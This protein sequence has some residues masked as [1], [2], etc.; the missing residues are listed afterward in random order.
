MHPNFMSLTSRIAGSLVRIVVL[1]A[2]WAG[3][4]LG[5]VDARPASVGYYTEAG[6]GATTFLG[7]AADYSR[8]GP[9][10]DIRTGYD[11]LSWLSLGILVGASTHEATVPPPPEDEYYQLYTLAAEVRFGFLLDR[12]GLFADAGL[13]IGAVSSNILSRVD[14]LEPGE[15]LSLTYRAGA[16]I[17]YQLQNRHYAFGLAGQYLAMPGFAQMQGISTR[18]YLRYTY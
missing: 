7:T 13:G 18:L 1:L 14:V 6:M 15:K 3:P 16:G 2:V 9:G 10:V 11:A 4:G 8:V 5:S 12:W 17:E